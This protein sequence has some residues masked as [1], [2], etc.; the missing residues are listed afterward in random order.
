MRAPPTSGPVLRRRPPC[1]PPERRQPRLQWRGN[2]HSG[3]GQHRGVRAGG[4]ESA[5][6]RANATALACLLAWTL[7]SRPSRRVPRTRPS[8]RTARRLRRSAAVRAARAAVPVAN[9]ATSAT[10]FRTALAITLCRARGSRVFQPCGGNCR[11]RRGPRTRPAGAQR[12]PRA[13]SAAPR[14]ARRPSAAAVLIANGAAESKRTRR[15]PLSPVWNRM[16][17]WRAEAECSDCHR[18]CNN[19]HIAG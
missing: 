5:L 6:L 7:G 2:R 12:S 13:G 15:P 17:A 10:A 9:G 1:A 3:R 14:C 16:H 11:S 18:R 4:A 19:P 8:G